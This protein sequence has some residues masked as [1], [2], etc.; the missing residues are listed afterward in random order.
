MSAQLD[1]L[2]AKIQ[3]QLLQATFVKNMA[4]LKQYMPSI[5]QFYQN[6]TP[7]KIQLAFDSH[8]AVNLIANNVFVYQEDP[9]DASLKQV[10]AFLKKPPCFD[11]EID[12]R[13]NKNYLYQ[14]EKVI[15]EIFIKRREEVKGL[16]P[17][18][19]KPGGQIN[20]IAFMGIGLGHHID[21]LF[22]EYSIRSMF[23][24]EPE[25]DVFFASLH[26]IDLYNWFE[27]CQRLGGELTFKIGG[28]EEEFVND[29][30]LYFKRE[31]PF[32]LPQMYLYRHYMSNKTTDAFKKINELAYRYKS[33]WGFCEDEIIGLSH[34]LSNVSAKK[35]HV[36]LDNSKQNKS[37]LPVFIIGN[38]PSLTD[39]LEYIKQ[40]QTNVIIISSG[41]SLKPLL[42]YGIKPDMHVEQERP[43]S[44][45]RWVK[46]VG[47]EETL[48]AMPLIC[49]NTVYPGILALFKEP[50][51]MLKAG[52]AGTSFIH[53]YIS[54]KY[55]ELYFC[56]PTV[57]NA[58]T[59]SAIAMGFKNI[60]LF[61]VDFGFLSEKDHHAEGSVYQD[62]KNYRLK[63]DFKVPGNFGGEVHTTR[64]FDFSRGVLEMLLEK[65]P[66]VICINASDGA[67]VNK[68]IACEVE[69]L[70]G[71]KKVN[72]KKKL[73]EQCLNSRF[74][75]SYI[76]SHNLSEEFKSVLPVFKHY[77]L[78]LCGC[79]D[80]VKT[81]NEL[82]HAFSLQYKF[83]NDIEVVRDKK[84]FYR[85]FI[86]SLNYLQASIMSN[87]AR[88]DDELLQ[89]EFIRFC[90]IQMQQ[91]LQFLF[92]DLSENFDKDARA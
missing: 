9:K 27:H 14:H 46:K 55:H 91:H 52:D 17:Y 66:D 75:N 42:D 47:H 60:Y 58:S 83:V 70:P 54:D 73:V 74:D 62:I 53:E 48:K 79:L 34:T 63:S 30:S 45:Y 6:Y 2:Q 77:I 50:Y 76:I 33:G 51:V 78:F 80:K 39:N 1:S 92:C 13:S 37:E 67:K 31:G 11:F 21:Q 86:G 36:L 15:N 68:T 81:K 4:F 16:A 59:S 26:C 5:Y 84:L 22:S 90:I 44:I 89:L 61:G 88:Y 19:L 23:I 56:N 87:V 32:N 38:G 72:N 64:T 12:I 25:P 18:V 41:T 7:Q 69:N 57:T 3:T 8:G 24:F 28:V 10:E 29:I 82:T 65:N 20:F 71:F 85:F 40:N 35:A 43:K 49:L